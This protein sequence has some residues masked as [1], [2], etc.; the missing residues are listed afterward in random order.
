[1]I[2]FIGSFLLMLSGIIAL[3]MKDNLIKKVI[4][5]GL[6]TDGINLFLISLGWRGGGI[7]PILP[8][9]NFSHF[10]EMVDPIP[11]ALVLTSIVIDLAVTAV[12][13]AIIVQVHKNFGTLSAKKLASG[14]K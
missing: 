5:L 8:D 4:G 7:A 14:G 1:M 11:Q 10:S 6:F 2:E 13:L 3:A 12:A 9:I